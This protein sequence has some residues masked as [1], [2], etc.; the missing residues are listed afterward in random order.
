MAEVANTTATLAINPF[1]FAEILQH[2]LDDWSW[3]GDCGS[4]RV[5]YGAPGA[6]TYFLPD[7]HKSRAA[8]RVSQQTQRRSRQCRSAWDEARSFS[9]EGVASIARLTVSSSAMPIGKC[10]HTSPKSRRLSGAVSV[11]LRRQLSA[12]MTTTWFASRLLQ[13]A[14]PRYRWSGPTVSSARREQGRQ[15]Q[16]LC[17]PPAPCPAGGSPFGHASSVGGSLPGKAN[18]LS[19]FPRP[20]VHQRGLVAL[21]KVLATWF[22]GGNGGEANERNDRS[23]CPASTPKD[24]ELLPR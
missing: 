19:K 21:R 5:A 4:P 14:P 23:A 11:S 2:P 3:P 20:T 9:F 17:R 1:G 24:G 15:G 22:D 16:H 13:A 12:E 18:G 6:G 7:C 8:G 10:V